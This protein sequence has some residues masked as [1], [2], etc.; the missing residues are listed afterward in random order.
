MYKKSYVLVSREL[1][2]IAVLN[3]DYPKV[4]LRQAPIAAEG[5][6]YDHLPRTLHYY[7]TPIPF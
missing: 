4:L 5:E 3:H 1:S 2:P 7:E 6:H